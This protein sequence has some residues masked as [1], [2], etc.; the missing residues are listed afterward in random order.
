MVATAVATLIFCGDYPKNLAKIPIY[1]VHRY[2][3]ELEFIKETRVEQAHSFFLP[4]RIKKTSQK[5]P[6]YN[7]LQQVT[8]IAMSY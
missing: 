6:K 5:Y 1:D 3:K 8:R 4:C 7:V 2:Y